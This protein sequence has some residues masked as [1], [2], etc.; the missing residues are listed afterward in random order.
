MRF[1]PIVHQMEAVGLNAL[2]IVGLISFLIGAVMVNQGAIQLS[3]FGADVFV[4]TCIGKI[5]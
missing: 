3:K 2:G 1:A 5:I 4:S